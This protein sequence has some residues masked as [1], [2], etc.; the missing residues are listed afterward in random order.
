MTYKEKK[1]KE[2]TDKMVVSSKSALGIMRDSRDFLS[3]TIDEIMGCFP[4]EVDNE[5][6]NSC[7]AIFLQNLEEKAGGYERKINKL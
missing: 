3:S 4:E 1:L 6:G 5:I 2:Y 7:R